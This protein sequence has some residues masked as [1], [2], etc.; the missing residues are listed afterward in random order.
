MQAGAQ[1][2]N[3]AF[4]G[5][6]EPVPLVFRRGECCAQLRELVFEIRLAGLLKSKEFGELRYL[7]SETAKSSVLSSN[8]LL[9]IELHDHKYGEQKNDAENQRRQCVD[10]ARPVIH[11]A[12]TAARSCQRHGFQLNGSRSRAT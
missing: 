10:E 9:Q 2:G 4:G 8:F 3:G 12:V 1:E 5:T 11:A 7:R 6:L